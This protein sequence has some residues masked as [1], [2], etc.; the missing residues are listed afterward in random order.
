MKFVAPTFLMKKKEKDIKNFEESSNF[1]EGIID[2]QKKIQ[3]K[4]HKNFIKNNGIDTPSI[5]NSIDVFKE[6]LAK[7]DN[8]LS[9]QK[10]IISN[11]LTI[12]DIAWFVYLRRL[13]T[14]GFA[15]REN[16]PYLSKWY[17]KLK[18]NK[19]FLEE[20]TLPTPLRI[21]S[22]IYK[23]YLLFTGQSLNKYL[24]IN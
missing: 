17:N 12:V 3:L 23:V 13:E 1:I 8:E 19:V 21:I 22:S 11:E 5:K 2:E 16:Y 20:T 10:F 6:K 7:I 24:D 9:K 14:I 4:F 18:K 15:F